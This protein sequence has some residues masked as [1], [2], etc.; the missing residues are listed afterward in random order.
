MLTL[1]S[2]NKR[3]ENEMS[4]ARSVRQIAKGIP[5]SD[6]A[7]VKLTRVIGNQYVRNLD[8]FLMLDEFCT[9]SQCELALTS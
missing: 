5:T 6:G 2:F 9:L 8:P 7:G 4:Q 1:V 3:Q